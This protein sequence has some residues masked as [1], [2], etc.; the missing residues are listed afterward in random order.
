MHIMIYAR[1]SSREHCY[2][3]DVFVKEKENCILMYVCDLYVIHQA[4]KGKKSL[5]KDQ[6]FS[7][8]RS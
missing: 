8:L 3:C 1:V 4:Y 2:T 7:F 5:W 6:D